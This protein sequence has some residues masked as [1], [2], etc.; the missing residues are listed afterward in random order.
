MIVNGIEWAHPAYPTSYYGFNPAVMT[1][2]VDG[3][4]LTAWLRTADAYDT[5]WSVR[6][7][8]DGVQL[9]GQVNFVGK[10]AA[11]IGASELLEVFGEVAA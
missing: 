1:A 9:C 7:E 6:L 5:I 11:L 2:E 8:R 10:E 3:V 4:V